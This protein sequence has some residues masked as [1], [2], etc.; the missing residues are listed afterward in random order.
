[1]ELDH[2]LPKDAFPFLSCHPGNL[3]PS[4]HDSNKADGHK[5]DRL[6]LDIPAAEQALAWF[7]PYH[8][9]ATGVL[10]V[11]IEEQADCSL[12][13]QLSAK[14]AQEQQRVANMDAM[15]RLA[16]FWGKDLQGT[17]RDHIQNVV[18]ELVDE[19]VEATEATVAERLRRWRDRARREIGRHGLVIS[20]EAILG[21][22][23]TSPAL[24]RET[25]AQYGEDKRTQA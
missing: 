25:L 18:D 24:V 17:I 11:C 14:D 19:S 15:F 3:V 4:C 13:L 9:T 21:F 16:E 2:F 1:M 22:A 8:R 20:R 23:A 6:P 5:G 10:K 7:H 12:K